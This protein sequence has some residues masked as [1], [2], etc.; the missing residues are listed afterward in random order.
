MKLNRNKKTINLLMRKRT[1][2]MGSSC[3]RNLSSHILTPSEEIVLS[4]GLNFCI[5]PTK[6]KREEVF[7]EFEVLF[8]QLQHHTAVSD[9][10]RQKLKAE[11]C[12]IAH[13]YCGAPID[14]T[15]YYLQRQYMD[16]ARSL[17][18]LNNI[19]I[20]RPDKGSGVVLLDKQNYLDKM[21]T[22]L[23]DPSKFVL[24]GPVSDFD[25]TGNIETNLV[26][27]LLKLKNG[28][29]LP[30]AVYNLVRPSGSLR[31]RMYG[32]PKIHK[33]GTPL[34]PILSMIKSPPTPVSQMACICP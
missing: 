16:A 34:R 7:A 6:V 22:I 8:G 9:L 1:G 33:P 13:S 23:D 12:D 18:A 3:V 32:L 21:H 31:P 5:P 14:K 25:R 26:S 27:K 17:R 20:S 2:L 10:G 29:K 30:A 15:D 11:L 24:L 28:K 4:H 19:I